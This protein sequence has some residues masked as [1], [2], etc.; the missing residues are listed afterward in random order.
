[1]GGPGS[2]GPATANLA[3]S[4]F[5][6]NDPAASD[7]I[8]ASP[9]SATGSNELAS[10]EMFVNPAIT[11]YLPAS[12]DA[13]ELAANAETS[14]TSASSFSEIAFGTQPM[15]LDGDM[16][17]LADDVYNEYSAGPGSLNG[18]SR[19]T[20]ALPAGMEL[21]ADLVYDPNTGLI[22][23]PDGFQ[24]A[25]YVDPNGNYVLAFAGTDS[26]DLEGD[27]AQNG[28]QSQ[29]LESSQYTHAMELALSLDTALQAQ[30]RGG[31][32][33][34]TG[35]SL[36]G[37]LAS[38]AALATGAT[39]VTFNAAG[40]HENTVDQALA[41]RTEHTGQTF[42]RDEALAQ[43]CGGQIRAYYV[44]GE[45]LT[46]VQDDWDGVIG[47]FGGIASIIPHPATRVVGTA[48]VMVAE[49]PGAAGGSIE[50]EDP[51]GGNPVDRH[52]MESVAAAIQASTPA[53]IA[54]TTNANGG[55]VVVVASPQAGQVYLEQGG[56]PV[57]TGQAMG[58]DDSLA[59]GE[60]VTVVEF[61]DTPEGQAAAEYFRQTGQLPADGV[62]VVG[63]TTIQRRN[64]AS[65]TTE[66]VPN[67]TPTIAD[68]QRLETIYGRHDNQAEGAPV[69]SSTRTLDAAGVPV[70]GSMTVAFTFESI[71]QDTADYI[72][73]Y[74]APEPPV[75][76][77]QT[78]TLTLTEPEIEGMLAAEQDHY[79][80]TNGLTYG[81]VD[82]SAIQAAGEDG[83][84]PPDAAWNY[85][86][87]G[88]ATQ[89]PIDA[90]GWM[91]ALAII[92]LDGRLPGTVTVQP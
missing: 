74:Y 86:Y 24:A 79:Y 40:L 6:D 59:E 28:L 81:P 11:Q 21:P 2:V 16:V 47:L 37:G 69:F 35:H 76:A 29:G 31:D 64:G 57:A 71:D 14:E 15:P 9:E 27:W 77:G 68:D 18:Y 61:E 78:V 66:T 4:V 65:V 13:V 43:A 7:Q 63:V 72:N 60:Q 53:V 90:F 5:A 75:V 54:D 25:L 58:L 32:F 17:L 34:I 85:V 46:G 1:M 48:L 19:V 83:S 55:E 44:G 12:L 82:E 23:G 73:Y 50:V 8:A 56:D 33:V 91:H 62:G 52:S 87:G 20:G 49:L 51:T 42:S 70:D 89:R 92:Q 38:A 36:G 80:E 67:D 39:A 10:P 26:S 3:S 88:I 45:I 22:T 30:G 41:L 84:L